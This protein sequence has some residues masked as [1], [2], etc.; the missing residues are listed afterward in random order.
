MEQLRKRIKGKLLSLRSQV[1]ASEELEKKLSK[2]ARCATTKEFYDFFFCA[3]IRGETQR[4]FRSHDDRMQADRR[5]A[6][7]RRKTKIEN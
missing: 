7:E 2:A 3:A 4:I 6:R 5:E 1:G